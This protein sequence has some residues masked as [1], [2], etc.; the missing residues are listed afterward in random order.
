MCSSDLALPEL[1]MD[2]P[3]PAKPV[4]LVAPWPLVAFWPTVEFWVKAEDL[5]W[6]KVGIVKLES[7]LP[8]CDAQPSVVAA[9]TAAIRVRLRLSF[10]P[11][12]R[13]RAFCLFLIIL[14]LGA[15]GTIGLS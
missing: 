4:A 5:A 13:L 3:I 11:Q 9:P 1:A 15:S 2:S 14:S 8:D 6:P 10:R 7:L 12:L